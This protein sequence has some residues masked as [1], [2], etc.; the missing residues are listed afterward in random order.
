MR[1]NSR[2]EFWLH[3]SEWFPLSRKQQV[4]NVT[5]FASR[6]GIVQIKSLALIKS[7]AQYWEKAI[8]SAQAEGKSLTDEE[9]AKL[10]PSWLSTPQEVKLVWDART[11]TEGGCDHIQ[12]CLPPPSLLSP[13]CV[14][15]PR[16]VCHFYTKNDIILERHAYAHAHNEIQFVSIESL[17]LHMLE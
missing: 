14:C 1:H 3:W 5:T 12:V 4:V 17:I 2:S 11:K 16:S 15:E 10:M 7:F 8:A 13:S 6:L 9:K